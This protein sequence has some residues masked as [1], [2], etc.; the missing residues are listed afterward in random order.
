MEFR[1]NCGSRSTLLL[2]KKER[3][4]EK[5]EELQGTLRKSK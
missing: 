4:A 2:K 1:P 3:K 5:T